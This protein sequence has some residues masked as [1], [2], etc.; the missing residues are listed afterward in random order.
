MK[1]IIFYEDFE[2]FYLRKPAGI[3]S[4]FGKEKSFLDMI[5]LEKTCCVSDEFVEN[6]NKNF[7]KEDEFGLMN[8]LDNETAGL[9]YFAKTREIADE[10][11]VLQK[12]GE[13]EKLYLADVHGDFP[14]GLKMVAWPIAHHK[15]GKEKMVVLK[16]SADIGTV[17]GKAQEALTC[18]EKLYY[19]SEKNQSTLRVVISKGVRHQIRTHLASLGFV[20]VGD[21][22]Y[23][24]N[25]SK[26]GQK[27]AMHLWSFGLRRK[28][29]SN[30]G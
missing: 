14:D 30:R 18:I 26:D 11:M 23:G 16:N 4:S 19:D 1:K 7:S 3:A 21:G 9:L 27:M 24:K 6:Q 5:F 2:F 13:L 12:T 25:K 17:R 15:D 28:I 29:F 8:R 10:F 20:I 22:L